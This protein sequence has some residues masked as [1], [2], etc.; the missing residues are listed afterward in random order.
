MSV[1]LLY[2]GQF[3]SRARGTRNDCLRMEFAAANHDPQQFPEPDVFTPGRRNVLQQ[4]AF[5]AGTHFC[6]G[7]PLARIELEVMLRRVA[8]RMPNL[9]LVPEQSFPYTPNT[10]FRALRRLLVTW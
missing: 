2:Y 1:L 4:V 6:L 5:G 7:A 3:L 8:A 10:S 9:A